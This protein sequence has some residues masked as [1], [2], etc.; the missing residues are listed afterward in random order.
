MNLRI[1]QAPD[2]VDA[3]MTIMEEAFPPEYGEAWSR[4]QLCG[5]LVLPRVTAWLAED[6]AGSS[7]GFALARQAPGE[8]ELLLLAVRPSARRRGVG[9]QLLAAVEVQ[10]RAEGAEQLFLEMR[11]GNDAVHLYHLHGFGA[12]G[13]RPRYY[14]GVSGEQI[15]AITYRLRLV[16]T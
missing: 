3:I 5:M 9:R 2:A 13:R 14:R 10:A 8:A 1:R 7:L 11:D 16:A 6:A 12:I 15:D 4:A